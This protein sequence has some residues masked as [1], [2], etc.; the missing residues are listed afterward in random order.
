MISNQKTHQLSPLNICESQKQWHIHDLLDVLHN[1]TKFQHNGIRKSKFKL[2]CCD[3]EIEEVKFNVQ[4]HQ[5]KCDI[6]IT[7]MVSEKIPKF[8][9]SPSSDIL[10]DQ[11]HVISL[12]HIPVTQFILC[13]IFLMYKATIQHLNYSRQESKQESKMRNLHFIFLTYL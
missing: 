8:E 5:A 13:M 7:F 11:K 9:F 12:A 4:Y 1:P 6:N 10:T 3:I 2:H